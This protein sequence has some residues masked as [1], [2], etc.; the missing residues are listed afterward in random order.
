[1]PGDHLRVGFKGLKDLDRAL[2]KADKGLRRD[3]RTKL[4]GIAKS[5]ATDAQQIAESK[6]LRDA[7][8]LV[9]GI[10]PFARAGGAGVRSTAIH[11]GFAYPKR[12]EFEARGGDVYG[13][14]ASLMPALEQQ[15]NNVVAASERLLDDLADEFQGSPT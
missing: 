9:D 3:L 15:H 4:R 14:R 1:M 5:V 12:L 2:G 8:D 10:R 11:R 13:P 6:G 7:G